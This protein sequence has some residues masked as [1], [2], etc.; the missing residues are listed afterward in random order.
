MVLSHFR[1]HI[2]IV[3]LESL[4]GFIKS[5]AVVKLIVKEQ[6]TRPHIHC[7]IQPLKTVSTFRQQFIKKFEMCK[8]N[9]CYSLEEVKD[10]E[11]LLAYMC[12]GDSKDSMPEVVFNNEV[13]VVAYHNK[14]WEVNSALKA[15]SQSTA[16]Q[17]KEKSKSWIQEVRDDFVK[18]CPEHIV[19]LAN[20]IECMWKPTEADVE[21]YEKS[22]KMLLAFVLKRLGKS[23]KVLDDNIVA[24]MFRGIHNSL[25]QDGQHADKFAEYVYGKLG[26]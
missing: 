14:Y 19:V 13:D 4:V 8:G 12:K 5:S 7:M 9:R 24:R 17:K 1:V 3:D 18:E 25:I 23:V 15:S 11:R 2:D 6:G 21:S 20:P 22:K 16:V 10:E 26:L